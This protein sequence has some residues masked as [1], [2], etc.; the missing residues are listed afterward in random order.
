MRTA[1]FATEVI[2]D[3]RKQAAQIER[4]MKDEL[5]SIEAQTAALVAKRQAELTE[6][7]RRQEERERHR[8]EA[9]HHLDSTIAVLRSKQEII[10]EAFAQAAKELEALS[11]KQR[12]QLLARLLERAKK[13]V[14]VGSVIAAKKDADALRAHVTVADTVPSIG[15][16]IARSADGKVSVDMRF[17]TI[18]D[19][20]R[21]Q[22]MRE[23]AGILFAGGA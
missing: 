4:E 1:D 2:A 3:A 22:R 23:V 8:L 21:Q 7:V 19:G 17:E 6:Q 10:D 18:L 13:Q 9:K 20:V 14:N 11:G 15:G 5:A 16:F 12:E